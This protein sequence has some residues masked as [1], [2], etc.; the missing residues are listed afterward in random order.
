MSDIKMLYM[1]Q[2]SIP[3]V[4]KLFL[5]FPSTTRW[6]HAQVRDFFFFSLPDEVNWFLLSTYS[7]ALGMKGR[8]CYRMAN[9]VAPYILNC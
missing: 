7:E 2:V 6:H 1:L 8:A 4:K 5:R 3:I 9:E